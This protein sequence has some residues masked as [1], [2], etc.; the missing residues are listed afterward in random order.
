MAV[1]PKMNLTATALGFGD[2]PARATPQDAF[3]AIFGFAHLSAWAAVILLFISAY[4]G[5]KNTRTNPPTTILLFFNPFVLERLYQG[6]WSLIIALWLLPGIIKSTNTPA[7]LARLWLASLTPSGLIIALVTVVIFK[8]RKT[9]FIALVPA[10]LLALPWLVPSLKSHDAVSGNASVFSSRSFLDVLALGG[11]WNSDLPTQGYTLLF[12]IVFIPIFVASIFY[13][14]I[15]F[16]DCENRIAL[17]IT[18]LIGLFWTLFPLALPHI[19]DSFIASVP[20]A[21]LLRDSSKGNIFL[22]IFVILVFRNWRPAFR[23]LAA[24]AASIAVIGPVLGLGV[25]APVSYVGSSFGPNEVVFIPGQ[26][27]IVN[28]AGRTVVDPRSKETN[29]LEDSSLKVRDSNGASTT[30]DARPRYEEALRNFENGDVAA[31][32]S[33]DF[34]ITLVVNPQTGEQIRIAEP[35]RPALLGIILLG[36]WVFCGGVFVITILV[37]RLRK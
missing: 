11:M 36:L 23:H 21:G 37:R 32:S 12:R 28:L 17:L 33:Q 5:W 34:E 18:L 29:M 35:K 26:Q 9:L 27:G 14:G 4:D 16:R 19:W 15:R 2:S 30:V 8:S 13:F 25:L 22:I 31:T 7:N 24:T 3:L 10:I 20:G 1:L 6:H